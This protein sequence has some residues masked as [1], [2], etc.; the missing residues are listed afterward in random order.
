MYGETEHPNVVRSDKT[1][2]E[3]MVNGETPEFHNEGVA[4]Q[5]IKN[6]LSFGEYTVLRIIEI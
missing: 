3:I 1:L 6:N 4:V 5:Y 2:K